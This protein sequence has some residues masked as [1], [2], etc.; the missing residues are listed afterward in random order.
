[1]TWRFVSLCNYTTALFDFTLMLWKPQKPPLA[2]D[3][4]AKL[5]PDAILIPEG[6]VQHVL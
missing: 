3:L 6:D 5:S 4:R 2:D 1:M